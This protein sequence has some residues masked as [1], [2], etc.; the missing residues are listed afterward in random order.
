MKGKVNQYDLLEEE[1]AGIR[2][3]IDLKDKQL[4]LQAREYERRLEGLNG[5]AG[6]LRNMQQEYISREVFDREVTSI[7]LRLTQV[8]AAM[9]KADGRHQLTQY[10]PWIIAAAA[11]AVD[12]FK[13]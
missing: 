3:E 1:I 13:K 8:E 6:R 10:V 11:I 7:R 12:Y 9:I 4:V 2:R 5:E